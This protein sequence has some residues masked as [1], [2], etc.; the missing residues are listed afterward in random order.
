[1]RKLYRFLQGSLVLMLIALASSAFAQTTVTGTVTDDTGPLLGVS[2]SVKGGTGTQTDA[3]G[4]YSIKAAKGA[5]LKFSFIGY[6]PKEVKVGEQSVINVK[7]AANNAQLNEV[8]VTSLGI[9]KEKRSIGYASATVKAD[10]ITKTA[11]TNF[12]TALYGKVAGMR[13]ESAPGGATSGVSIQ[14]RG[15]N[16]ILNTSQP[17]IIMDGVPIRDV[18]RNNPSFVNN[19]R[20]GSNGLVDLNAEDIESI[21]VLKGA[22]A[23]ALYGSEANNGVIIITTKSGKGTK[24]VRVDV[25][26]NYTQDK[27]AYLPEY[28]NV[29]GAGMPVQLGIYSSDANGFG[30]AQYN[31]APMRTQI[32]GSLNFG[33]QFDGKPILTWDG[34]VRPYSAQKNNYDALFQTANNSNINVAVSHAAEN[35]STRFSLADINTEG[36]SLGS[37]NQKITANLNSNFK[38]GKNYSLDVLVN[39]IHQDINNRP[40]SVNN[41]T[42]GFTGMMPRFDNGLWY[43]DKYK[44]SLGYKY[45]SNSDQSLTPNENLIY[46]NRRT[47]ILDYVWNVKENGVKEISN[48]LI[49]SVT[50]NWNIVDNLKL[51][52]RF[53][54]DLTA[55]NT[56]SKTATAI[57]TIFGNSTQTSG[58]FGL[59]SNS[60]S[61]LYGDVLLSYN[62]KITPDFEFSVMGGY[63][64]EKDYGYNTNIYTNGLTSD[65]NFD[66]SASYLPTTSNGSQTSQSKDAFL[67]TLN[68]NYKSFLFVEGTIRRDRTSTMYPTNNAFVYPSVNSGFVFSDAFHL[69]SFISYGKLR[70]SW[71][72]VGSYPIPY[73][74]N[75]AYNPGNLGVQNPNG[76]AV[77]TTTTQ[78][79]FGNDAIRPEK[80]H[81]FEFGLETKFFRNRLNLD[82]TYYNSRIVD[83]IL[84]LS[85]P[86]SS[87]ASAVLTNVGELSNK[88]FE[89]AINGTPI[90]TKDFT[91]ETGLN[92]ASN[93]NKVLKLANGANEL[94][95]QD[96]DGNAAVL[97]S[98]VGQPMGD[99]Y[100]HPI[101]TDSK[102]QKIVGDDGVYALDANKMVKYGNA[103]PTAVGGYYNTLTYK[104]FTLELFADFRLGGYVMPSG[105]SWLTSR[106]LTKESL[107][108]MDKAHGGLS[109]YMDANGKGIQ[110]SGSQGPGGQTVYNDGMLMHGVTANGQPNTNVISQAYYY[111]NVYNWG[112]PQYSE[113]EYSLYIKKNS[114]VKMREISFGYSLPATISKKLL[115]KNIK[116]SVFGRNLFYLYRTI[117]GM[118]AE[119]LTAGAMWSQQTSNLGTNPSTR[120]FGAMLRASF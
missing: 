34:V 119:Q 88:G 60:Y 22:S 80:K 27:V 66:L 39:F 63:T 112:G 74:A 87:G 102:G 41:L 98:V 31:G 90:Q 42:Q 68:L 55:G 115:A 32:Q 11:S 89:L 86:Q 53:S 77:L 79:P 101:A 71:G 95:H 1:M 48:R 38:L 36:V 17:L 10:E 45:V 118:D 47:D 8:V 106:G 16:S 113:S 96:F 44:T 30:T 33:P 76:G 105:L 19:N 64:A 65:N 104:S 57:P 52:A 14:L 93:H 25:N 91:W 9:S 70:A 18:D 100:A 75:I 26:A 78:S 51:R 7:L 50:N 117:K 23:A 116:L 49:S 6:F 94:I 97:K 56:I 99:F 84:Q 73:Q 72:I 54:T 37:K 4:T 114:Y 82:V 62:K 103:M 35:S 111:W 43:L 83:Q 69:P 61:I 40:Y 110:A 5:I 108:N 15:V 21:S 109:Y 12:A 29:R 13:I 20:I 2:I 67:G 46:P 92:F 107:N 24:G 59:A 85:L 58:G 81:E 3:N 28:Q 120:T